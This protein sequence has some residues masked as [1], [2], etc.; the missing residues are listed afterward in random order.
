MGFKERF[1]PVSEK[2]IGDHASCVSDSSE[3]RTFKIIC[4]NI[5]KNNH[6]SRWAQ[7]FTDM[8][9]QHQ[10]D[11]VFLQEVRLPV[12]SAADCSLVSRVNS[13]LPK[14]TALSQMTWRFAPNF[15]D[16]ATETYSGVLTGVSAQHV[17]S[18]ALL[19]AKT[20][21]ITRTPKVS[22]LVEYALRDSSLLT[23]NTHLINFVSASA[24]QTQLNQIEAAL[25]A[26]QGA[27]ILA[28]DF[29][30]WNRSRQHRLEQM[31]A[32]LNL[33]AAAFS[34]KNSRNIKRFLLSPPL[35]H[36]FYRGFQQGA[37]SDCVIGAITA[38]DHRPLVIELTAIA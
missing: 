30:T 13:Q 12:D 7:E 14:S 16:M 6:S 37:N 9:S 15:V 34:E 18:V 24:F 32:R 11:A 26:H 38:S 23:V 36:I 8:V 10:P 3:R 28:G 22:L 17:R 25:S 20:E 2:V 31:V 29:N 1:A 5:N 27:V 19:T 33:V 35:D 4:W 21:P